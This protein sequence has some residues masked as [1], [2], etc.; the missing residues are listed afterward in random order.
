MRNKLDS[1]LVQYSIVSVDFI[2]GAPVAQIKMASTPLGA[3]ETEHCHGKLSNATSYGER[4]L[5]WEFMG[6]WVEK[7]CLVLLHSSVKSATSRYSY[8]LC[9]TAL[10][11][12]ARY[13]DSRY[14][15]NKN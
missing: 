8:S 13:S 11:S 9:T 14:V 7:Y 12:T 3:E 6:Q 4:A 10:Y 1:E 5:P 2:P 15:E